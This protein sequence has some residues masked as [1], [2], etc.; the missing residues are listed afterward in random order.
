ME[1]DALVPVGRTGTP[2]GRQRALL[3]PSTA[4]KARTRRWGCVV[5]APTGVFPWEQALDR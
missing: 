2:R 3:S 4:F 5:E 1:G